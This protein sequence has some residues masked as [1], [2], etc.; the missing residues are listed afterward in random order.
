MSNA[1]SPEADI[2]KEFEY[3]FA[4][5]VSVPMQPSGSVAKWD[6]DQLT[7]WGMGQGIYPVRDALADTHGM[8]P[9]KIRFINK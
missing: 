9:A 3:H 8:D 5:A 2:V 4:G 1:G 6:G 7:I